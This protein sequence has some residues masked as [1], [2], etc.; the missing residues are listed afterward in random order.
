[1]NE[2]LPKKKHSKLI[3]TEILLS[4]LVVVIITVMVIDFSRPITFTEVGEAGIK[5]LVGASDEAD[6]QKGK[7]IA[8]YVDTEGN[9]LADSEEIEGVVGT[10]YKLTRK[11]IS[12]YKAYGDEPYS[13]TGNFLSRNLEVNFIYEEENENVDI[14][15]DGNNNIT[16]TMKSKKQSVEYSLKIITKDEEGNYI[17]GVDYDVTKGTNLVRSGTVEGE[18]FVAGTLTI[19]EEGTDTYTISEDTG[20]YYEALV[21]SNIEFSITKTWNSELGNFEIALDYDKSLKGVNIE[22]IDSEIIVTITNKKV[23]IPDDPIIPDPEDP[24]VPEDNKVF[25]L[26]LTKYI[27]KVVIDNGKATKEINRTIDNKDNL[28]KL[29]IA[30][31]EIADTKLTVTYKLLV[32]NV[33]NVA[34]YATE[35][36]DY[37][38]DNFSLVEN[39]DWSKAGKSAITNKLAGVLLNPGD[40]QEIEVSFEWKLN[41]NELGVRKNIAQITIY[42]NDENL[43]DIT[44]DNIGSAQM[45]VTVKTGAVRVFGFGALV[46]LIIVAAVVYKEKEKIENER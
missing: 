5:A 29:E 23:V 18:T 3:A 22:I 17:K 21:D 32:E 9:E 36:T 15:D 4:V 7:V 40:T 46:T 26:N 6:G 10:E 1:M 2:N 34:G 41:E 45:I 24:E 25:D 39:E 35:I 11:S 27:S 8:N 33:G 20:T 31:N 38:P 37:I 19:N 14:E 13:K 16:V 28:L 30:S 44:P 42:T 43:R 12:G